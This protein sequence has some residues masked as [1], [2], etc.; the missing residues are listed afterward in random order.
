MPIFQSMLCEVSLIDFDKVW[1]SIC[2]A[3]LIIIDS[4]GQA[5]NFIIGAGDVITTEDGKRETV[6]GV[7]ENLFTGETLNINVTYWWIAVGSVIL[8]GLCLAIGA[9]KAQFS[10]DTPKT[11]GKLTG[12][13]L[14]SIIK[15]V[16]M[17]LVFWIALMAT[18]VIFNFLLD[19]MSIGS[20]SNSIAQLI[21]DACNN[22]GT[23]FYFDAKYADVE[24][25]IKDQDNFQYLMCI[26]SGCFVVVTLTTACISLTKRFVEVFF[27]YIVAPIAIARTPLD[28]GK[29][30]DLWKEQTLSKLLG[31]GGII[32]CMYLFYRIM[33][34]FI[35]EVNNSST[36]GGANPQVV[37]NI[38]CIMFII[39]GSC[40]PA[41]ATMMFAQL[42]SQGAG[43]N[44]ANNMMH[45]QQM[46]GNAF[47]LAGAVG[48]KAVLGAITSGGSKVA[49]TVAKSVLGSG[50]DAVASAI[51]GAGGA[52]NGLAPIL[53]ASA[54]TG[55]TASAVSAVGSAVGLGASALAGGIA[56]SVASKAGGSDAVSSGGA[57]KDINVKASDSGIATATND[58]ATAINDGGTVENAGDTTNNTSNT[59]GSVPPPSGFTAKNRI[60]LG[61]S[62]SN[63]FKNAWNSGKA[64]DYLKTGFG[65]GGFIGRNIKRGVNLA[66]AVPNAFINWAKSGVSAGIANSRLG[67][68]GRERSA[69]LQNRYENKENVRVAKAQQRLDASKDKKWNKAVE[70]GGDVLNAKMEK[71]VGDFTDRIK[72]YDD[73][74]EKFRESNFDAWQQQRIG[75]FST[76]YNA[77]KRRLSAVEKNKN[78]SAGNVEKATKLLNDLETYADGSYSKNKNNKGGDAK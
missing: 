37:K 75:Q 1:W 77:V 78:S 30:F 55:G 22:S 17:P 70:A 54:L 18:G 32:I 27:Y 62:M 43:Q 46:M 7:L 45:T 53:G 51:N 56:G 65:V 66:L 36:I 68:W 2:R 60:G 76:E 38:I 14:F 19:I 11:L 64:S 13:T 34:A 48:G 23:N 29:S 40:V 31:A 71:E 20:T 24:D 41:S 6:S 16:A 25:F 10:E 59:N 39:G 21:C 49:S 4:I 69:N 9:I 57:P 74:S 35:E 3:I 72:K 50:G 67:V 8:L 63:S 33:P 47:R 61:Q 58:G 42:I 52:S 73:N 12:K 5:F 44:E 26:L 15:I 28:D